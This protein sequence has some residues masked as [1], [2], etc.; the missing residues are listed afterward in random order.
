[1]KRT[2]KKQQQLNQVLYFAI[3]EHHENV[4]AFCRDFHLHPV[5]VGLLLNLKSSPCRVNGKWRKISLDLAEILGIDTH[6]L[7]SAELYGLVQTET[8]AEIPLSNLPPNARLCI[9]SVLNDYE[10]QILRQTVKDEIDLALA[11]FSPKEEMILRMK[12]GFG[13]EREFTQKEIGQAFFIS[14]SRVDQITTKTLRILS[15]RN[16][17]L[18]N[19]IKDIADLDFD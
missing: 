11:R 12:F 15:M 16:P 14:H 1:M 4:S 6:I 18:K 5:E 2:K 7:F 8:M 10:I 3:M 19:L 9:P 17:Q 13:A